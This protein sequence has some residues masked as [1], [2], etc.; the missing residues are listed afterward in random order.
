MTRGRPKKDN[1]VTDVALCRKRRKQ[2]DAGEPVTR[3]QLRACLGDQHWTDFEAQDA[4]DSYKRSEAVL[5]RTEL[6]KYS[7]R[8]KVADLL[9]CR[10]ELLASRKRSDR[11]FANMVEDKYER[12]LEALDE[13]ISIDPNVVRHLDRAY[14]PDDPSCIVSLCKSGMPRLIYWKSH[15]FDEA[16]HEPFILK[17]DIKRIALKQAI[18]SPQTTPTEAQPELTEEQKVLLRK[19]IQEMKTK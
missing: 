1:S 16:E 9:D 19:K 5:A 13:A 15:V 14:S 6:G 4:L 18:E 12:A 11:Q 17:K 7:S 3:K 8:F 2:L 10:Y